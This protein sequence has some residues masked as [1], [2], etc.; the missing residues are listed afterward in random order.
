MHTPK[1]SIAQV[2]WTEEN[3]PFSEQFD[4]FYFSTDDGLQE[5]EY[6]FLR[7]NFLEQRFSELKPNGWFRIAETGF[8]SGLNFLS[9]AKLWFE[10]APDYAQLHFISFEK[11]PLSFADLERAHQS[12]SSLDG[13]SKELREN[14]PLLLP[15]WHDVWLFDG[16]IRLTLWF[17]DVLAGLPEFDASEGSKVD[18]WLLDGF[19]P[20]KNPKM[21]QPSLYQQM[22]RLSHSETTFATFTAAGDVRRGLQKAGF[23]V[24]KDVGFGKKRE[25]CFGRLAQQRPFSSKAPW[26]SRPEPL[27]TVHAIVVGAGLAGA[28]VAYKLAEAGWKVTVLEEQAQPATQASGNWAGAVHPLVTADWNLRSQWY[29]Q[30]F[31]ATL[32]TLLPWLHNGEITGDLTGLVQLAVTEVGTK[33]VEE[34][35]ER[36]GLPSEF[37][38]QLTL[39]QTQEKV[40]GPVSVPGLFFPQGGWVN[41]P[42][43]VR[44]CLQHPNIEV[45]YEQ[46]VEDF[47]QEDGGWKVTTGDKV[48]R[49][50]SLVVATG[51]LNSRLNERLGLPIR[52]VKGQ[53]TH[54]EA[55]QQNWSLQCALTHEGYSAPG[56]AG[57]AVTGATFEAPDMSEEL[58]QEGHQANLKQA[59]KALPD[60]LDVGA[61]EVGGR[62]AFRPTTPDHLPIIGPVADPQWLQQAYLS[63]SHTH[64]VYRYPVQKYLTGLFVSNGH[65][66]RGLMSVFLAAESIVADLQGKPLVQPLSLYQ[67]S[68]PARFVIRRW[69]S[70]HYHVKTTSE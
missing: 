6:V 61:E 64:A 29:L 37:V 40:G 66:P 39:A 59:A 11:Y 46:A 13:W 38:E 30:G 53:V 62:I 58:S 24:D 5:V 51:S 56:E 35:F 45:C 28:S 65:G 34:A 68:H 55:D 19:T 2:E 50:E 23:E 27:T 43:V 69:R 70:G 25:M 54:L 41:P 10:T 44:R 3:V 63:Q 33:R 32:R 18:A 36:V 4:D 67:A 52:P 31:E 16:R 17:G 12:Y 9:V 15:G 1:L 60:W 20:A 42:S 7:H 49:G 26:F 47:Q 21:W 8:G 14:Y 57:K 48:Y 22:A